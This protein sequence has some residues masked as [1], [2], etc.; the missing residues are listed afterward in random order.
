M[1]PAIGAQQRIAK[2]LEK[3]SPDEA[4]KDSEEFLAKFKNEPLVARAVCD[5]IKDIY[6]SAKRVADA[7][8]KL[9]KISEQYRGTAH[10]RLAAYTTSLQLALAEKDYLRANTTAQTLLHDP[11]KDRLPGVSYIAI[12]TALLKTERCQEARNIFEK[13]V[14][15][16][17]EDIR[18][19]LFAQLGLAQACVGLKDFDA[20]QKALAQVTAAD[21]SNQDAIL[22][23][24]R[25]FEG[26]G[27]GKPLEDKETNW[28]AFDSYKKLL[29]SKRSDIAT[30]AAYR[31][32]KMAYTA[33]LY[34]EAAALF[35][36]LVFASGPMAD[37]G[38]Y[39]LGRCQEE[40]KNY[41]A[42]RRSYQMYLARFP[43]GKFVKEA[44]ERMKALPAPA[45]TH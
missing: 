38:M 45:T 19:I 8:T 14:S 34:G 12:G 39:L 20:A 11:E 37:E 30:E 26:K 23:Q 31:A 36:R 2:I 18:V 44:Q 7:Y 16:T 17:N 42:A 35:T 27:D 3:K 28:R 43:N 41:E 10:I 22:I 25:I 24:A 1:R 40:L 32:G 6:R 29:S 33:K 5:Q 13:L 21:P 9:D 15:Q 4:I